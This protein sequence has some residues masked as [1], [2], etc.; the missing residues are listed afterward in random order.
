MS[1]KVSGAGADFRDFT[2][3]PENTFYRYESA[4]IHISKPIK[5]METMYDDNGI[6]YAKSRISK[7]NPFLKA[8]MDAIPFLDSSELVNDRHVILSDSPIL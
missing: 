1:S 6:L 3:L 2:T 4:V 5:G 8:D 7:E